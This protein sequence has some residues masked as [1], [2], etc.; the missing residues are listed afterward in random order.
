M[1]AR[2][3]ALV[4]VTILLALI[5]TAVLMLASEGGSG[6]DRAVRA[7]DVAAARYAA[8]AGLAHARWIADRSSCDAY[9]LPTTALGP[10][11]YSASFAP[12]TNSPV[13][14]TATGTGARGASAQLVRDQ[15]RVF[16]T[17]QHVATLQLGQD[18][19]QDTLIDSFYDNA[20][21][22][23]LDDLIVRSGGWQQRPLIKFDLSS[24]T[25][26][27][28]VISASL[29][30]MQQ[31]ANTSG[32]V[33]VH[34][35]NR[36]W[37]E[38]T[39]LGT[40]NPDGATWNT[41]DGNALWSQPGGE[42]ASTAYAEAFI[43]GDDDNVWVSWDVRDLVADWLSG[44]APNHGFILVGDGAVDNAGFS[45]RENSNADEAP[46][47]T[48]TYTCECGQGETGTLTLQPAAAGED[49]Y[50]DDGTPT[51]NFGSATEI[52]LSNKTNSKKR[53]L[54][55]FDVTAL[56][57]LATV[58]SAVLDLNLV[59][60]GSGGTATVYLHRATTPWAEMQA[61]WNLATG[62]AP[63][64]T[65]GGDYD[66]TAAA[67]A[68]I[69][70]AVPGSTLFPIR[71]LV[72][73][74]VTDPSTNHGMFLI[75]SDGV[76]HADFTTG[77]H[78]D[79]AL[80]PTL[81]ISYSCPCGT[82]CG[83]PA[84]PPAG[85]DL[86]LV[87][88]DPGSLNPQETATR[89]LIEGWG[90][91]VSL[92]AEAAGTTSFDA[93]LAANDVVYVPHT[94]TSNLA[95]KL[96]GASIG[97]V[98]THRGQ[99]IELGF[100]GDTIAKNNFEIDILD[101]AHHITGTF[102]LGL[103]TIATSGQ[104]LN[105]MNAPYAPGL[106]TLSQTLNVGTGFKPSLGVL[107]PGDELAG[108]GTAAGRRV[109]LPWGGSGFDI[110]QLNADGR[111]I[112]RRAI[113]WGAG[114]GATPP[115]TVLLV[116]E[117]PAALGPA[118]TAT[119]SMIESWGYTVD[120][121]DDSASSVDIDAAAATA[122]VVYVSLET[123]DAQLGTK[124]RNVPL[125]VVN[126][127]APL[128]PDLGL[129]ANSNPTASRM[130]INVLDHLHFLTEPWSLGS[131]SI[132]SSAQPMIIL[133]GQKAP[134]LNILADAQ[135]S[136]SAEMLAVVDSGGSLYGG[137]TA[138]ARRVQL[139]WGPPGFDVNALNADGLGLM[140]RAVDWG[141]GA[142]GGGG[143]GGPTCA[144]DVAD[145]FESSDPYLG[146]SGSLPWTTPWLE[147]NE[148]DGPGIGD[149]II[150]AHSDGL[151]ARV[152][153]NDGGGE[154]LEREADLSAYATATLTFTYWRGGL[155]DADDYVTVEMSSD[156]GAN[157][158]EVE[159]ITGPGSDPDASPQSATVD[160]SAFISATTRL[161]FV[162]SPALAAN[163][164]V[165]LDNVRICLN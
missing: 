122:D 109:A 85:P 36:D 83:G 110:G 118:A 58:N 158:T 4:T 106:L 22:G 43:D 124:L 10:H 154:G 30:L 73:G 9:D 103:L 102:P 126:E 45:A 161:R 112:M 160:V 149:E 87:V 91:T 70:A 53:G 27:V 18:P 61:S 23:R 146:S 42:F 56:P 57:P 98:N 26:S 139:P 51:D 111:E 113:E 145:D 151:V 147:V 8:E 164:R 49:T 13:A 156:G 11:S 115:G 128:S 47:L 39:G 12:A 119:R 132:V 60:I 82:G 65:A 152:Q 153:D 150:T 50:L 29:Q 52:R 28:K 81:T 15:V 66:P 121:I 62:G 148:S 105:L 114:F 80:H 32:M 162:T 125:G 6:R 16:E 55:R 94:V 157:W 69:D 155:D 24:L 144:A 78:A 107:E 19:G 64:T 35:M 5:A 129:T 95:D 31:W 63:W 44:A 41:V 77:D 72:Q 54:L 117:D 48:I 76:N 138:P 133:G 97:V 92:I 90:Y 2:G 130:T 46:M 25:S 142:S 37:V 68:A 131:V 74:W 99:L 3:F 96:V 1:N 104:P 93:A 86:L 163:E 75:G 40:G 123:S 34:R 159:R 140:R 165:Y 135:P 136:T 7:Q 71:D 20:N 14:I 108:G 21:W 67:S 134:D 33:A 100:S 17:A 59:G 88:G 84:P 120:L 143:G 79:P 141:I 127:R 38:G 137:G 101:N 89:S 116:V